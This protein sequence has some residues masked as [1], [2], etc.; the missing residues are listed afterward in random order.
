M[1]NLLTILLLFLVHFVNGQS[2]SIQ[3]TVTD[4][5]NKPAMFANIT[6]EK[7]DIIVCQ[8]QTDING[9][10]AFH[11]LESGLYKVVIYYVGYNPWNITEINISNNKTQFINTALKQWNCCFC[12]TNIPHKE[13]SKNTWDLTQG[14]TFSSDKI[15]RSPHKN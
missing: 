3:G 9:N 12:E 8:V 2:G 5:D 13:S 11:H 10:Y 1:K 4:E 14:T 6:L 15:Q 7:N